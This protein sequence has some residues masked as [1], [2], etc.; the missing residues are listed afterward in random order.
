MFFRTVKKKV[1]INISRLLKIILGLL[2]LPFLILIIL[3]NPFLK[4]RI[5]ELET[6]AI[7]HFSISTEIF[8]SELS[9][10]THNEKNTI[11]FWFINKKISNKFLLEK[12][13]KKINIGPRIFLEPLFLIIHK[14]SFLS[15]LRSPFR[16]WKEYNSKN[17]FWQTNDIYNVLPKTKPNISFEPEEEKQCNSFL[18]KI[19]TSKDN[20]IC[21]FSRSHHY[22]NDFPQLKDSDIKNQIKG[23]KNLSIMNNIK[24]IRIG[25]KS[26]KL[27]IHNAFVFDYANSKYKSEILDIYL[28]MNCKFMIGTGSG[29]SV[30]PALNRK[31]TLLVDKSDIHAP[32]AHS[33][34]YIPLMITKK[35][36]NISNNKILKFSEVFK[37]R[38]TEFMYE[39]D[40]NQFGYES[41][42]NSPIEISEAILEMDNLIKQKKNKI[43][44]IRLQTKFWKILY[45]FYKIKKPKV[46]R[47]CDSFLKRNQKLIN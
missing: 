35:F 46:L 16:H 33:E 25:S 11:Y 7:G 10:N 17:K 38:L 21:F 39:K 32:H 9:T 12:W 36:K 1:F 47:I 23:I 20:Y 15:F 2:N 4:I 37:L 42:P 43:K 26:N 6:R 22:Y 30:I 41:V 14:Y 28:P 13:K 5:N 45:K 18:K 8:L 3:V 24:A 34:T 27:N 29:M 40:L 31:K 19:G 44:E